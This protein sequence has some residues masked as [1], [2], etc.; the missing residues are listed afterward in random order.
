MKETTHSKKRKQAVVSKSHKQDELAAAVLTPWEARVVVANQGDRTCRKT[1]IRQ[2]PAFIDRLEKD[3][4]ARGLYDSNEPI[5][6][7]VRLIAD[8]WGEKGANAATMREKF[9]QGTLPA[10]QRFHGDECS[11]EDLRRH[12][13]EDVDVWFAVALYDSVAD[14]DEDLAEIYLA[15]VR[16]MIAMRR[17]CVCKGV[18]AAQAA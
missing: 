16:S 18:M 4:W 8:G 13:A 7:L 9:F 1:Q 14:T 17:M 3:I 2:M 5:D 15:T 10:M 11:V 12:F 6:R